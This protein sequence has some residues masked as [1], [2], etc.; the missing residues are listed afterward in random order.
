LGGAAVTWPLAVRAQSIPVG[1]PSNIDLDGRRF[2]G[3]QQNLNQ[4][5]YVHIP[6][7]VTDYGAINDAQWA[8]DVI[9]MTNGTNQVSSASAVWA[10]GDVGKAISISTGRFTVP[11]S[12]IITGFTDSRHITVSDKL[13]SPSLAERHFVAWG[14]NCSS[15]FAAFKADFQGATTTLFIP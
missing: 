6:N 10:S 1:P 2:G 9:T 15:A 7:I 4:S 8:Y 3:V 13:A 14:T 5:G 12:T 11:L